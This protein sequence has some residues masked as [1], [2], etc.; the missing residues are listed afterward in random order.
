MSGSVIRLSNNSWI[1]SCESQINDKVKNNESSRI[2][3]KYFIKTLSVL[4]A[5]INEFWIE[6]FPELNGQASR[7]GRSE[8]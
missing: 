1:C 5:M 4:K 6:I 3:V 8:M 7:Q 2:M